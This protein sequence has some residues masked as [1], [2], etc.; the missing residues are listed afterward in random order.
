VAAH[1]INTALSNEEGAAEETE[2]I[3]VTGRSKHQMKVDQ[4]RR[5]RE[6]LHNKKG[7]RLGIKKSSIDGDDRSM[8]KALCAEIKC[9]KVTLTFCCHRCVCD[10]GF[11]S[12]DVFYCFTLPFTR[13]F[14]FNVFFLSFSPKRASWTEEL[15]GTK[16]TP[17]QSEEHNKNG[18]VWTN[19]EPSQVSP[20]FIGFPFGNWVLLLSFFSTFF[21]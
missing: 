2:I 1:R 13:C 10:V 9:L 11:A 15:K 8:R 17:W 5:I 7:E 14:S 19:K 4:K 16:L 6:M 21:L 20:F 12:V 3:P 18:I